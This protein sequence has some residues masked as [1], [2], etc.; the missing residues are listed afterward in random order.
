MEKKQFPDPQEEPVFDELVFTP[1]EELID[2]LPM[3]EPAA[4]E[5]VL[6][7]E[8]VA[9]LPV[10]AESEDASAP[11]GYVYEASVSE[12]PV[13]E[14]MPVL[15]DNRTFM[16]KIP[17][18]DE[19]YPPEEDFSD[20]VVIDEDETQ[21]VTILDSELMEEPEADQE[22]RDSDTDFA[23]IYQTPTQAPPP[24]PKAHPPRK[25]RPKRKKG[26]GLFGIP[27]MLATVVWLALIL[28]IGV[29][30]GRMLWV[31]AADVLAFGREDKPVTITIYESDTMD[32]IIEKLYD[33]GLIRYRSLFKLYADISDAQ[34]DI[35]P[36]IY[37]LNTRYD[38]HA[39]VN[40]M[41]TSSSRTVVEDVLIPE[42]YT[43]RQ[44][45]ALLEE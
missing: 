28:A 8:P 40:M 36:G 25:G 18:V 17:N 42:G 26:E 4:A 38:Y 43:C 19:D 27:N 39:L 45:F 30:A 31:C 11:D 29:T 15:E 2:E 3:E 33:N 34:E 24:P 16:E 13:P 12:E 7:E 22:Y 32:D 9:D 21:E 20:L 1:Q 5:E 44:I 23:E 6:Q 41:S 14:Q 35:D 10:P 37:D